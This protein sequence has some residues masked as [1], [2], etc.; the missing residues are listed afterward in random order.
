MTPPSRPPADAPRALRAALGGRFELGDVLGTGAAGTVYRA[1]TLVELP[2]L[3]AGSPVAIKAVRAD[4]AG[5]RGALEQL[6]HEGELG[7]TIDSPHVVR[8]HEVGGFGDA[9][10]GDATVYVVCELVEGRTL[11]AFLADHGPV[12]G[13]LARRIGEQ[14]ARGLAAL[15]AAGIVHRDVKPENVLI[16][17]DHEVRLVDLGLARRLVAEPRGVPSSDGFHGSLA[18]AAP[19]VLR[20]HPATPWSDLY[21]LGIVLFEVVT[22][23]HPFHA[24]A[25]ADAMLHAHLDTEP[26]RPSHRDPRISAFL[27]LAILQLLAKD[28]RQR[29]AD[30]ASLA[31][32]LAA[33]ESSA[34]WLELERS[35]P[36]L[37][38]RRRLRALR[39]SQHAPFVDRS[40]ERARL[41]A[42]FEA[43]RDGRGGA[44]LVTGPAGSGRR[45]LLDEC[46]ASW[47][48]A[49]A[50]VAFVGGVAENEPTS[51]RGAPFTRIVLD[52][53][54]HGE[55]ERSPHARERL[56][57][58]LRA[59]GEGFEPGEPERLAAVVCGAAG[60][61]SRA[62][63]PAERAELLVRALASI[64]HER[65]PLIVRV[66]HAE[67][68]GVTG[69]LALARLTEIVG[70][71]PLLILLTALQRPAD[72]PTAIPELRLGGLDETAFIALGRGLF[73]DGSTPERLLA[74]AHRVLAGSPGALH[75]SLEELAAAG[76]LLGRPGQYHDLAADVRE[77][78]PARPALLRL[79]ERVRRMPLERRHVLT[80]AA[81]LG[82]SFAVSD[83]AALT[84]R[85]E[86]DIL[87]AL[88]S[89]DER[90]V[91]VDAGRGR[92]R[93]R[94]YR[95]AVLS[96]A[97]NESLRRLH[98]DAAWVLEDHGGPPL[99]IGMHLSRAGEHA[100]CLP[101]LL[102]GL[103]ELVASGS[104]D[105]AARLV[106]RAHLHLNSLP[107]TAIT[108]VLRLR[109]LLLAGRTHA[110]LERDALAA[111]AFRKAI[112]LAAHLEL[113]QRRAEALVG[114]AD[115]AQRQGRFLM[116]FQLLTEADALLAGDDA[117]AAR[118][119]RARALLVHERVLAYQGQTQ[120]ALRLAAE[121]LRIA[122]EEDRTLR[123]HL[124]VDHARWQAVHLRLLLALQDL[125]AAER[126]VADGGDRFAQLRVHVHRGR[127][128]GFLGD[129]EAADREL[130]A[131]LHLAR[132][133]G[134]H[135][136]RGRARFYAAELDV[137]S[138]A[139]D[140]DRARELL[141]E[142]RRSASAVGDRITE[143]L[144]DAYLALCDD[145][146]EH[147][148][149]E[150]FFDVPVLEIT[151]SLVCGVRARAAGDPE[152]AAER[153]AYGLRLARDA[154]VHMLLRI[155]LL[156]AADQGERAQRLIDRV[157][158][159]QPAGR[160]RR[161]FLAYM[162]TIGAQWAP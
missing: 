92:F 106:E 146:A 33:G 151:W 17:P 70:E 144:A 161:R 110:M 93:H 44:L 40:A 45:R 139:G 153:F 2:E 105:L 74:R 133:L 132:R 145:S 69:R 143:T 43:A 131:A 34:W 96:S 68:L 29:F 50:G 149:T 91:D 25:D 103:A 80:A 157:A 115:G 15:H 125:D 104:R 124:L 4:R 108:N 19:E 87:E 77:L 11:R 26:P 37:A 54:L 81:V 79:R 128:L 5:E 83:L 31:D 59:D 72:W 159:R 127:L 141:V 129:R 3:P 89:F 98:R 53:Y 82:S 162:E 160:A 55:D 112:L 28:P 30:A 49:D 86:L 6:R 109:W 62:E 118:A 90:V 134:D 152:R 85:R 60:A 63:S 140:R 113:P 95:R 114:L 138:S 102:D 58:R 75:E 1:R 61:G 24:A 154:G 97:P 16:T 156:R 150:P 137:L 64:A 57:E 9:A 73:R 158:E 116:A 20:G 78:T 66:D 148:E 119:T 130:E 47:L 48:D 94:D 155:A 36:V 13:D 41:D 32:T 121:A 142:A 52:W 56:S 117:P 99:E 111:R 10:A 126:L 35:A 27:D 46:I 84:G 76:S 14:V 107:R 8:I 65:R 22:G 100:A 88:A 18:Y 136:L 51:P 21:A 101:P 38:S 23:R 39:R 67:D 123:A 71:L 135:R 7:R 120:Q 42:A 122:P 12:I 147:P